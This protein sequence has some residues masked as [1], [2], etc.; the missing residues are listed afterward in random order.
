[1]ERTGDAHSF[2]PGMGR[3]RERTRISDRFGGS[4]IY[5]QWANPAP[6]FCPDG[7]R[8]TGLAR[9]RTGRL[10]AKEKN[11]R[12]GLCGGGPQSVARSFTANRRD[13]RPGDDDCRIGPDRQRSLLWRKVSALSRRKFARWAA[14]SFGVSWGQ[15]A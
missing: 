14:R 2:C 7:G 15:R 10:G 4:R 8:W 6:L 3:D 9:D 11:R 12:S 1:C 5:S 13:Q